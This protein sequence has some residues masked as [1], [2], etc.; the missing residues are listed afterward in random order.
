MF[1][2]CLVYV[3]VLS[4]CGK[5]K[6]AALSSFLL[7]F[8]S[9][10]EWKPNHCHYWR[11]FSNNEFQCGNILNKFLQIIL[12]APSCTGVGS[13]LPGSTTDTV[14]V[15]TLSEVGNHTD[16]TGVLLGKV[17]VTLNVSKISILILW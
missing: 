11:C 16:S 12:T 14:N 15:A 4:L 2:K 6:F 7:S 5:L 10:S 9:I 1:C 13:F 8:H 3:D 17:I